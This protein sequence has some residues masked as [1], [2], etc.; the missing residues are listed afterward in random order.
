[1]SSIASLAASVGASEAAIKLVLGQLAGYPL[2]LFYRR[3][4]AHRETILQHL[5]FFL[6]GLLLGHWVVGDGVTHNLYTIG[7]TY[8]ILQTCGGS[9]LSVALSFA[10]NLTYL[11][12][13][14]WYNGLEYDVSWTM[15]Q[16]VLCLRLI[17]LTW[18]VYDG[19]RQKK[20]PKSLT[21]DQSRAALVSS[22]NILEMLSHCFFVG[23][24]FVGP[25]FT[26]RKYQEVF[27]SDYQAKLPSPGP[28][29]FGTKRLGLSVGYMLLHVVGSQFLPE[30]WPTTASYNSC[31]FLTRVL[32]LPFWCKFILAKYLSLWLMV[33]TVLILICTVLY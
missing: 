2:L 29:G 4:L 23:G 28:V 31:S 24:Y 26:M 12:A 11:L 13:G 7:G 16:C 25:Q 8:L 3:H 19:A 21:D 22:P 14:Y 1:M 6:S 32:L 33:S 15:P 17:G 27:T 30:L 20:N 10:L 18:D 5:Y 9:I